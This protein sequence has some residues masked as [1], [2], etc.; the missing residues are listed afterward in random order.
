MPAKQYLLTLHRLL[1]VYI[2]IRCITGILFYNNRLLNI[3]PQ[4]TSFTKRVPVIVCMVMLQLAR[5]LQNVNICCVTLFINKI[6]SAAVTVQLL[7]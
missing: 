7:Q 5:C 1:P 4:I 3:E 6:Q 2:Q